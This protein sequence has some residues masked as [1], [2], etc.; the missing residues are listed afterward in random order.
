MIATSSI[1]IDLMEYMKDFSS[2]R[3]DILD[4][5]KQRILWNYSGYVDG[6]YIVINDYKAEDNIKKTAETKVMSFDS[7]ERKLSDLIKLASPSIKL[8]YL[9]QTH[10]ES[11]KEFF[12]FDDDLYADDIKKPLFVEGISGANSTDRL[13]RCDNLDFEWFCR[14]L[15]AIKLRVGIFDERLS[16]SILL[17]HFDLDLF[18][19]FSFKF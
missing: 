19:F 11:S 8:E 1:G 10:Y 9:F 12:Q 14:N 13:I 4:E 18:L 7:N 17:P 3:K 16:G 5:L 2:G 15:R 6:E